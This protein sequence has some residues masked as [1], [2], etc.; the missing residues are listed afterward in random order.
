MF[1]SLLILL[2][3]AIGIINYFSRRIRSKKTDFHVDSTCFFL[4]K[5]LIQ[6]SGEE[7]ADLNVDEK[8]V[9]LRCNKIKL[10]KV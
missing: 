10:K 8:L 1:L 9:G 6:R 7:N 5:E 4:N 2:I 3:T